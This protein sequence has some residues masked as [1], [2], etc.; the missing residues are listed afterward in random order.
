MATPIV[1]GKT[2]VVAGFLATALG[3]IAALAPNMAFMPHW[4]VFALWLAAAGCA[5]LVGLPIDPYNG[6]LVV[7]VKA[8]PALGAVA[9]G[10]GATG[11]ALE[12]GGLAQGIVGFATLIVLALT[13]KGVP[14]QSKEQLTTAA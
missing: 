3:A 6:G 7:A 2:A 11:A 9:I 5:F 1:T 10:L 4:S 13:G 14:V 12:P 8:V